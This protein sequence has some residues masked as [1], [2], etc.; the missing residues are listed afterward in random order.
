MK[1]VFV[2]LLVFSSSALAQGDASSDSLIMKLLTDQALMMFFAFVL[3]T[4]GITIWATRRTKSANDFYA[5]GGGISGFQNGLAI[6]A[7]LITHL[8]LLV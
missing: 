2:C 3:L 7:D 1:F 5:A 8:I 4:V 6:A